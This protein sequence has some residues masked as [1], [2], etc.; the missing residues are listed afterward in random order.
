MI[1]MHQ[2]SGEDIK[3]MLTK[4]DILACA[5]ALGISQDRITDDV[6]EMVKSRINLKLDRWQ[7]I[8]KE[9]LKEATK[10]PLGLICYPSCFWWRDGN[11]TFQGK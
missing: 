8:V 11:C 3:F 2:D 9:L 6:I 7:E 1:K 5:N 10:C 4:S